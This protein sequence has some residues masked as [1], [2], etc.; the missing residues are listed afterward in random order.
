[1]HIGVFLRIG[2]RD[3]INYDLRLL[4]RSAI[5]QS[6]QRFPIYMPRQDREITADFFDIKHG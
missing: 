2:L 1:M 5:V 4:G 6:D 3:C